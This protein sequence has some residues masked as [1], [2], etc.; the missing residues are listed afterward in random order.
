MNIGSISSQG[1]A[2]LFT[3]FNQKSSRIVGCSLDMLQSV[4]IK[5]S[6]DLMKSFSKYSHGEGHGFKRKYFQ[7]SVVTSCAKPVYQKHAWSSLA[8]RDEYRLKSHESHF[9]NIIG[10]LLCSFSIISKC[11]NWMCENC[12]CVART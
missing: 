11:T 9:M 12:G 4:M 10:R 3:L 7:S 5:S 1:I 2:E 8:S 6:Q